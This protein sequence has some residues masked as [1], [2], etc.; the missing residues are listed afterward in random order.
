MS[1]VAAETNAPRLRDGIRDCVLV[2][3]GVRVGLIVLS[4]ICGRA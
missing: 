3:L 4:L 1:E 2:F